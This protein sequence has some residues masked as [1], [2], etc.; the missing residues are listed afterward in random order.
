LNPSLSS[1]ELVQFRRDRL[2]VGLAFLLP[3]AM[4]F[5]CGF[6]IRLETKNIGLAVTD[7]SQTPLSHAY[8]DRL[9]A[10]KLFAPVADRIS[11]P[12]LGGKSVDAL[13]R[14][15]ARAKIVIPPDFAD[16]VTAGK[17]AAVQAI[18]DGSDVANARIIKSSIRAINRF[19]LASEGLQLGVQAITND[20]RIWFN[21]GRKEA[22]YIV[23]GTFAIVLAIYPP[24]L[25]T[26]AMVREKEQGTILQTYASSLTAAEML[27]GKSLAYLVI[28]IAE[29][30]L[31]I[32]IGAIVWN[33]TFVGDPVPFLLG[34]PLFL[35]T[36]IQ[37]GILI[38][39]WTETQSAAVQGVA[40]IK[41]MTAVLLSGFIFPL[42]NIP[43][44]LSWVSYIVPARYYL[45]LTR[46]AFVR[47]T[48]W[49]GVWY[50][51]PVLL[52]LGMM[53][54]YIAWRSLRRMQLSN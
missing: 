16:R 23:P 27:L 10:S 14:G 28:G 46:D 32:G 26:I 54:F 30:L 36:S 50:T 2:T 12:S 37:L 15:E 44:P 47:G 39:V 49:S 51:L 38:G 20:V 52:L 17:S 53:E 3:L 40:T 19:F 22:L 41:F 5:I 9:F 11:A 24:L 48:G 31:I 21:P 1:Y 4:L 42:T 6:A 13:D 29:A 18:V 7:Y 25:A 8:V 34:T 35:F 43:F 45:L 33:L